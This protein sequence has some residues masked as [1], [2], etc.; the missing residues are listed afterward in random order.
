LFQGIFT[1]VTIRCG[2]TMKY[3]LESVEK[4]IQLIVNFFT[5]F[6]SRV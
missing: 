3:K 2:L 4:L 6:K 1:H 5:I